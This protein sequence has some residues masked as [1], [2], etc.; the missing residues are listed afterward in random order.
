VAKSMRIL[1]AGDWHSELHEVSVYQALRQLG[2]EPLRFAWNGY[3]K[4]QGELGKLALPLL[5]AQCKYMFGPVV[6]RVNRDLISRVKKDQPDVVFIYRGSHVYRKTLKYVKK[7][8]PHAVIVGYNND[9]PFSPFYPKW[10][11]RHFISGI[12]EYDLVLAFRQHNLKEFKEAGAKRVE[13]MR[14]WFIPERN[15][16]VDLSDED[17]QR[18]ECDVVFVGHYEEDG[19][20]DCLEEIERRGWRL[21]IFG[22]GYEWDPV[23]RHSRLLRKHMPVN[24]VWSDDYNRALCGAKVALCFF[25]KL[26]RDT[27]TTRCFEIPASG[28]VLMSEY[29]DD[30]AN[31]YDSDKEAVFF[32]NTDEL[33]TKLEFLLIDD[34]LRKQIAAAGMRRV[35]IDGHD[36]VSRMKKMDEWIEDIMRNA[37]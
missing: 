20:L 25:S 28:A 34:K 36:V 18:F 29:S 8:A 5:R 17:R 33:Q 13:L 24:L 21:R 11:W 19:R 27:Y 15:H 4:P 12:P 14:H 1:I 7:V 2:H 6:G 37:K 22:P 9:D 32:R 35:W 3:F 10:K 26:N 16:P 31:M 30:I 23:I